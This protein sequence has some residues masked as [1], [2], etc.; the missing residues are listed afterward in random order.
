[1]KW[2]KATNEQ[3][4]CITQ[5]DKSCPPSLM[6]GV[7][8]E[9]LHRGLFDNLI[10][11]I[12]KRLTK[13]HNKAKQALN[14][15]N[16]DV[17]SLGYCGIVNAMNRWNPGKSTF[18]TFAYMNI[19]SEFTHLLDAENSQKREIHKVTS[20]YDVEIDGTPFHEFLPDSINVE[21]EVIR[22]IEYE[23]KLNHLDKE[24]KT[25]IELF[26]DGYKFSEISRILYNRKKNGMY[27]RD[28]FY[29]ALREIGIYGFVLDQKKKEAKKEQT[30]LTPEIVREIREQKQQFE[31]KQEEADYYGVSRKL[32]ANIRSY[33]A[34]KEVV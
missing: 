21:K 15:D 8:T 34:W 4:L 1:M 13:E 11:W 32:I 6:K 20:S 27:V 22:H 17:L 25:I 14:L 12:F 5:T 23:T 7:V 26:L 28:K 29:N 31:T 30:K 16:D 10:Y 18:K 24:D 19:R 9:A 3:L 33:K 2:D